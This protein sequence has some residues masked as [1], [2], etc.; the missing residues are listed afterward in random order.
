M[1]VQSQHRTLIDIISD[2][3][4]G[5][6]LKDKSTANTRK[7]DSKQAQKSNKAAQIALSKP[8]SEELKEEI[9]SP[10]TGT[11][12]NMKPILK[13]VNGKTVVQNPQTMSTSKAIQNIKTQMGPS[14]VQTKD[15]KMSS[16]DFK[17][18]DST[19]RWSKQDTEK[20]YMALQLMGTDFGLIE[21]L[22]EGKRTRN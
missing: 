15:K 2:T 9:K 11:D 16:L 1:E 8:S 5:E 14:V 22:F 20:F 21:T 7:R 19:D 6:P 4:S 10:A 12:G 3:K 17:S 13:I 18:R